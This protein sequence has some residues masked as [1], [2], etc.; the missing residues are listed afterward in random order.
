MSER[1]K[2]HPEYCRVE[3]WRNDPRENKAH[4][5]TIFWDKISTIYEVGGLACVTMVSGEKLILNCSHNDILSHYL[6]RDEK[7]KRMKQ[8][9]SQ[10]QSGNE[11]PSQ[12]THKQ[13]QQNQTSE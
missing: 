8:V 9:N 4:Y 1:V 3:A 10:N 5:H 7:R 11:K 13:I 2:S 6:A 12:I